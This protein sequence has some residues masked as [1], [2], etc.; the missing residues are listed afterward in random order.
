MFRNISEAIKKTLNF[1]SLGEQVYV[2]K[3]DIFR[4]TIPLT[5]Q[6]QGLNLI[7]VLREI[8]WNTIYTITRHGQ[9]K[10]TDKSIRQTTETLLRHQTMWLTVLHSTS[11]QSQ[12]LVS[13]R[14][15]AATGRE[16][17]LLARPQ[18]SR[19]T[20]WSNPCITTDSKHLSQLHFP[21][22][23]PKRT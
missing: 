7:K 16:S 4:E 5:E 21:H 22:Y 13:S 10:Q 20:Q 9:N 1:P 18:A 15:G 14:G 23:T 8:R 11:A 6:L 19:G 3:Y 17:L 2:P 12:E